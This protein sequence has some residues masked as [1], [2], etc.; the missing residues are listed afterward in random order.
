MNLKGILFE[1]NYYSHN[2]I[3]GWEMKFPQPKEV[4]G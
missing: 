2:K 4:K 3:K 1:K